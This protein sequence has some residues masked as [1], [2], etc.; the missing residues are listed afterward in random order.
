LQFVE[1]GQ[2]AF[3]GVGQVAGAEVL[4]D[5]DELYAELLELGFGNQFLGGVA[6][7]FEEWR[8]ELSIDPIGFIEQGYAWR[9]PVQ[10]MK[11][12]ENSVLLPI[13]LTDTYRDVRRDYHSCGS[14]SFLLL[15]D[16]GLQGFDTSMCWICPGLKNQACGDLCVDA[17]D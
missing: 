11:A 8:A 9:G 10:S 14:A 5:R 4:F 1:D 13:S 7:R 2:H 6:E 12:L 16:T 17:R 15:G 3:H